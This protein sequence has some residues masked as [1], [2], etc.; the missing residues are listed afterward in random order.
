MS[1]NNYSQFLTRDNL[2]LLL[3]VI[4]DEYKDYIVDIN[5]FNVTFNQMVQYYYYNE[6]KNGSQSINDTIVMNKKFI[7]FVSDELKKN[8]KNNFIKTNNIPNNNIAKNNIIPITNEDIKND[9]LNKF[10]QE[11]NLKQ[12][13]FKNA[14]TQPIPETP[15]FKSQIDKPLSEIDILTK[16]MLEERENDIKFI[17]SNN[18]KKQPANSNSIMKTIQIKEELPKNI[19]IKE[20]SLDSPNN[21]NNNIKKNISWSDELIINE[22]SQTPNNIFMKLKKINNDNVFEEELHS[23]TNN[24]NNSFPNEL[25]TIKRLENK[26]D[27][28]TNDLNK[29]YDVVTLLFNTLMASTKSIKSTIST[30]T[31]TE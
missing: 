18:D 23:L 11:L 25:D 20:E 14:F 5:N 27:K 6:I 7:L 10:D 26:I 17:Y 31:N 9:R 2:S 29:C 15:N 8:F 4:V 16:K 28:L 22:N 1:T 21:L 13:E 19:I 30:E 24:K 12:T 3:E